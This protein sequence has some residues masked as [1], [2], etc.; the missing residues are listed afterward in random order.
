MNSL[1]E[2]LDASFTARALILFGIKSHLYHNPGQ[3]RTCVVRVRYRNPH[4]TPI[5]PNCDEER[6]ESYPFLTGRANSP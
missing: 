1:D 2:S 3:L 6:K 5:H 4:L